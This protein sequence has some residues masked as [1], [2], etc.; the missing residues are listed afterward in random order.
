MD[1]PVA[2]ALNQ[3]GVVG[4][5]GGVGMSRF[6]M[7]A[8]SSACAVLAGCATITKGTTQAVAI[9]TPGAA[10]AQCTLN[11]AAIGSKVVTT[12]ATIVLEKSQDSVTVSC[13]KECFQDGG[14][15]IASNTES[16]AAGNIIAGGFI[17]LGIDAASG[18][19]NKYNADNQVA[20]VPIPG[21]KPKA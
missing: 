21:C 16:M 11:S 9:N 18:A 10:G 12:P 8:L 13:K 6:A 15:V 1:N 3:Y 17:G 2:Y 20:M 14:T 4:T 19:M 5:M 7:F